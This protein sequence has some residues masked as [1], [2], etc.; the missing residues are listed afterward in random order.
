MQHCKIEFNNESKLLKCCG[1]CASVH[2]ACTPLKPT[3]IK[4]VAK[5]ENMQW[6]CDSCSVSSVKKTLDSIDVSNK[7]SQVSNLPEQCFEMIN[8]QNIKID[9][10]NKLITDL[11]SGSKSEISVSSMPSCSNNLKNRNIPVIEVSDL[12]S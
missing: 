6:L 5:C 2:H 7:L 8:Q 10:Q 3:E 12:D 4:F 11:I 1:C 9:N